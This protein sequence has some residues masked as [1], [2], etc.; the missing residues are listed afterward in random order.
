M[1]K[2]IIIGIFLLLPA[3]Y[4][5]ARDF[6]ETRYLYTL[7]PI[8]AL[9]SI[10]SL[11]IIK[12]KK[13]TLVCSI[14]FL[15]ILFLSVSAIG[16]KNFDSDYVHQR[17]SFKISTFVVNSVN[18]INYFH[19]ESKFVKSAEVYEKWPDILE[20]NLHGHIIRDL[21]LI[22]TENYHSLYKFIEDSESQGLS[23][24]IVDGKFGRN[25]IEN[26]V[27]YYEEKYPYLVKEYDSKELGFKHHVKIF[28][29]DYDIFYKLKN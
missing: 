25:E 6:Q 8:I 10:Y 21:K 22:T 24:I 29:I 9:F 13:P 15:G 17:E 2:I 23:H 20:L 1:N 5:Y 28:K 11:K 3:L 14:V 12:I 19:P 16:Y 7:L 27:F 18:G 4:M 26:D